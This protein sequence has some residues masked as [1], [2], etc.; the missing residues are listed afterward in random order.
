MS[1]FRLQE[2]LEQRRQAEQQA[3]LQ[4]P[5]DSLLGDP[6]YD[7]P[8]AGGVMGPAGM[9]PRGPQ[10]FMGGQPPR[11]PGPMEQPPRSVLTFVSA[12]ILF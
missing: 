1:E 9:R 2:K 6:N 10:M 11:M 3:L 4:K 8:Q 5:P 12:S 7:K